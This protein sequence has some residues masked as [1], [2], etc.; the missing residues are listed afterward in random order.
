MEA[1]GPLR[2][3]TLVVALALGAPLV[4]PFSSVLSAKLQLGAE[5]L[6]VK[7]EPMGTLAEGSAVLHSGVT[8]GLC[9]ANILACR[10]LRVR[11]PVRWVGQPHLHLA[12]VVVEASRNRQ[13][14]GHPNP[15]SVVGGSRIDLHPVE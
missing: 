8:A 11:H 7:E 10:M 13:I 2:A 9:E 12:M 6:R 15:P 14:P 4:T 1:A 5:V 3:L